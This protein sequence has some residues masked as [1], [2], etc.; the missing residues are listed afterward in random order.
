VWALKG[1]GIR[2]VIAPSFGEIF[3]NNCFKNMVLPLVLDEASIEAIAAQIA[4]GQREVSID[5]EAQTVTA[6]DGTTFTFDIDAAR[7]ETLL[8]GLDAI[9]V[10][11]EGWDE[12]KAWQDA[13]R[14]KRPWNYLD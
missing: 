6:P 10:T 4:E 2:C 9:G 12:I 13:D 7:K 5:L 3:F 8:K 11:L 1:Y 14:A